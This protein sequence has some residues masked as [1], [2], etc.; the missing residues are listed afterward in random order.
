ME[1][2][3]SCQRCHQHETLEHSLHTTNDKSLDSAEAVVAVVLSVFFLT[4]Y[5][6]T[7]RLF[8]QPT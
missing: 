1:S 4:C 2:G 8:L 5:A 6:M 7:G 3:C